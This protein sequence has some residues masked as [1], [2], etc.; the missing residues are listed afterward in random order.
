MSEDRLGQITDYAENSFKDYQSPMQKESKICNDKTS[1]HGFN[2]NL[3][4]RLDTMYGKEQTMGK[5]MTVKIT[6]KRRKFTEFSEADNVNIRSLFDMSCKICDHQFHTFKDAQDHYRETHNRSGFVVC[7]SCDKKFRRPCEIKDHVR[8]HL[9][10][11]S[12]KY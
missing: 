11:N 2:Q 9:Q 4:T 5:E 1:S 6:Q 8:K 7:S 3:I 10:P 12:F